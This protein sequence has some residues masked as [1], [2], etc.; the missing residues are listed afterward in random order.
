MFVDTV[1]TLYNRS[2]FNG[3]GLLAETNSRAGKTGE[4][5]SFLKPSIMSSTSLRPE[6]DLLYT[7]R[8]DSFTG[9]TF[10]KSYQNR[11][12]LWGLQ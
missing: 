4:I 8:P 2:V 1:G 11:N 6:P 12:P 3:F 7:A 9:S 5:F 10:D